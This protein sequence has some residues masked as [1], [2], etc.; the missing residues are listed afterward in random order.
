MMLTVAPRIF[1]NES[2]NCPSRQL[3]KYGEVQRGPDLE[4]PE[5]GEERK[6]GSV[7]VAVS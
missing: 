3:T 2:K 5:R 4:K 1:A 6:K 7:T